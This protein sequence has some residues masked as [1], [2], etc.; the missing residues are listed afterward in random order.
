MSAICKVSWLNNSGLFLGNSAKKNLEMLVVGDFIL[1]GTE[2]PASWCDL[3]YQGSLPLSKYPYPWTFREKLLRIIQ[4]HHDGPI[5]SLFWSSMW[6]TPM[7][8]RKAW[9]DQRP[10]GARVRATI[11]WVFFSVIPPFKETWVGADTAGR[12]TPD[13]VS[14]V[15]KKVLASLIIVLHLTI[16][17][18]H[19]KEMK[20]T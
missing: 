15:T 20:Y 6:E 8:T 4:S 11:S 2:V 19:W 7:H 5:T 10:L 14:S 13:Y 9:A 1:S 18:Y 3:S 12:L 17:G 16:E